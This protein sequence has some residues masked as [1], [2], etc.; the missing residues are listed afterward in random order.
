M[1]GSCRTGGARISVDGNGVHQSATTDATGWH[2]F[3]SLPPGEYAVSG[4]L[5]GYKIPGPLRPVKVHSKGCATVG[6]RYNSIGVVSGRIFDKGGQP[7]SGVTV[8]AVPTRPGYENE[9]PFAADSSATERTAAMNCA[10]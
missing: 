1:C 3:S 7:A 6:C 10:A 5:E 4:S 9:L 8:E 2:I